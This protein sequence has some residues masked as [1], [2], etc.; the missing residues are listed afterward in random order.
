MVLNFLSPS[1]SRLG[2]WASVVILMVI[3][4]KLFSLL[5]RRQKL[6]RAMD[7]FPGPPTHWL[8]GHAL[9]IQ[10]LGS[11]DKVVSW[12]QQ[13]PHAHPLW[14]GQFVGFLNI[15]E[16]DYAKAVYSRGDP[17]AADVYDFFLQWI[18]KGLLV[19]DGPKWFQ[20][21]KLL[22]P[23]FHYD[24]LKP[25][26]A[27]FAESTRMMLDKWEKKASENKSFD[28]FCDVGHM[29]LDTLMKCTFGKGDSGLGHRDN[30]YYLAVSDLTLLMQQRIDSFQY[31]NDF[32][33]WLTPHG[34]RF[35]RACKIA[36][37]HTDEVIRQRKAAL[38]DEKERKKIQQRRHLD[39]LDILLGVRDESGIKL[40]DAELRAEVD[41]FMFEGHDTTTSGISWF[42]YC[43]ALYPE[44][45]QLCREEVRG[46]LGDQDSF[47][48]D[49]LAKMTYLTMCMKECFR[50]YPPV[51]QVYRQLNK[52]VTF[53]DG[54]SLPAG[55]LISLH[56][57]ALHRNSTVWPDPEVFDPLRFSPENA[58]GRH[59]FAFMP[60]SAGPRNC[61]G[62]Q[63][64]MNEM[65]VV[66]ALCLLR[67]EF[68]LDPS[69]MPIKVPQLI[70]RSKNGIHLYLKPL[71]SRS[72]K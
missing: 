40:S 33:Y 32:I 54:R 59:P 29:A 44:H 13:F 39:F 57:Y 5:L 25:Y 18:G 42:L 50:L 14:F 53:V 65:K 19:L 47:Q 26:V 11:L 37:D 10:K 49:D 69:K 56:I 64:A 20:H 68:S 22:T 34:R 28:I 61:I 24:V 15:Y 63:F 30:S 52:P 60:F 36:H 17:K 46:I 72:G 7:S 51:P 3:V 62:Q 23:G 43:M 9:E 67:F 4:L 45:Q 66:T 1:L 16:P 21:R 70:L 2:L 38:Q 71:A 35:L 41:T 55:S 27:I 8:F 6:A 12:A 48:W 58:A 31:H